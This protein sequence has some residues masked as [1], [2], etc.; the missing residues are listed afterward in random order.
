MNFSYQLLFTIF[1]IFTSHLAT[2]TAA[3]DADTNTETTGT[4]TTTASSETPTLVWVTG[5]DS[6]GITRT[7]QST[8]YQTFRPSYTET[9]TYASGSIG[10]GT[11]S[12]EVGSIRSYTET[13]ISQGGAGALKNHMKAFHIGNAQERGGS[14][15]TITVAFLM[16]IF[17]S[18]VLVI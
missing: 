15:G 8:F 6:A 9:E 7:T 5:T 4:E 18:A 2:T 17:I 16:G 10:V 11:I 14:M 1:L 12:G 13:T 3:A